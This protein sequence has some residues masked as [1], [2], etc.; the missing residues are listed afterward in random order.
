MTFKDQT[1]GFQV[2][3]CGFRVAEKGLL[4]EFHKY[5][6]KKAVELLDAPLRNIFLK[7]N[8]NNSNV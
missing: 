1:G 2:K 5:T 8:K 7:S 6:V 4:K 3:I